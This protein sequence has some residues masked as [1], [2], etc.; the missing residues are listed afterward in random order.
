VVVLTTGET[1]TTGV[2]AVLAYT[3]VTSGNMT[4]AVREN[5]QYADLQGKD[6]D[7]MRLNRIGRP[8]DCE[9]RSRGKTYCL[10]VFEVRVGMA[11]SLWW[12][13]GLPRLGRR[14]LGAGGDVFCAAGP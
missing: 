13:D 11:T 12:F 14:R 6:A 5:R 10:R 7:T 4:A 3:A 1:T 8:L 2:L 9:A